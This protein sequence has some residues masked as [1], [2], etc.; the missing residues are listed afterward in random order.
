LLRLLVLWTGLTGAAVASRDN[1]H[2]RI[3]LFSKLISTRLHLFVQVIVGLFTTSVCAI[4]AWHGASWV[5]MDYS[6][7]LTAFQDT[8]AWMLEVIIPL[9]FGLIALRYLL[10]SIQWLMDGIRY[11][12]PDDTP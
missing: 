4:I 7:R 8:P 5:W 2:I 11:H 1:R 3:D 6:D 10:H 9:A 12:P